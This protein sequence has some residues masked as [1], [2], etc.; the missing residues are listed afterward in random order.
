MKSTARRDRAECRKLNEERSLI[1]AVEMARGQFAND[2]R[3]ACLAMYK[4]PLLDE[5]RRLEREVVEAE[6]Q[7]AEQ[8]ALVVGLKR[9]NQDTSQAEVSWK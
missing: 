4:D 7:L 8:E 3:T 2:A 9:Q 5:L 1:R 6:R